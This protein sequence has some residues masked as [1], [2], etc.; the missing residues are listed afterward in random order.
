[1]SYT[2]PIFNVDCNIWNPPTPITDP[3]SIYSACQL[4]VNS[5]QSVPMNESDGD[6]HMPAIFLRLPFGTA[7]ERGA[8]V[9]CIAGSGIYYSCRWVERVHLGFINQYTMAL[10][11]Q[12]TASPPPP[13]LGGYI[14]MED[15]FFIEMED[16]FLIVLE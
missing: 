9:E 4:Y 7:I 6:I 8:F 3:P 11:V 5:R 14:L 16:G 10:L 1:M 2:P 13:P 12:G 15:G